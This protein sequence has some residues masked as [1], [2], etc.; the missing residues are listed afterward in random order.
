M[1]AEQADHD[2]SEVLE[3]NPSW[4]IHGA[5]EP[6]DYR[7]VML[8]LPGEVSDVPFHKVSDPIIFGRRARGFLQ[9]DQ[10]RQ[11][12]AASRS[13]MTGRVGLLQ[14]RDVQLGVNLGG[15]D[16]IIASSAHHLHHP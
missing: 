14:V 15:G 12:Q 1:L 16:L 11:D 6:V 9:S 2:R 10:A 8:D 3:A 5:C 4:P 13:R 7:G